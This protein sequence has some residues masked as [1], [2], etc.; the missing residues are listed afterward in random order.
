M[1]MR[2]RCLRCGG[3]VWYRPAPVG[4]AGPCDICGQRHVVVDGCQYVEADLIDLIDLTDRADRAL[5]RG[6]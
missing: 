1:H 5:S 4:V 2:G 3:L 6:R